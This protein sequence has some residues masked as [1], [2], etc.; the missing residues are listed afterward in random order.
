MLSGKL[1]LLRCGPITQP[2]DQLYGPEPASQLFLVLA[3]PATH[4]KL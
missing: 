1:G 3:L 2:V 4:S